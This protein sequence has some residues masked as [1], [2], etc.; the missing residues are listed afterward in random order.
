MAIEKPKIVTNRAVIFIYRG[1]VIWGTLFG[2][3]RLVIRKPAKILPSARRLI[4]L[5]SEGLFSLI[6]I[7]VG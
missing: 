4:E 3:T 5:I 2:E 7:R 6:I 1:M